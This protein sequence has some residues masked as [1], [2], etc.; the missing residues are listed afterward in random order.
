MEPVAG[1][2]VLMPRWISHC[3]FAFSI[4]MSSQSAAFCRDNQ[5]D[6]AGVTE[7]ISLTKARFESVKGG[8]TL[9]EV[10]A[11]LGSRVQIN[12]K[13]APFGFAAPEVIVV[14][15]EGTRRWV[16]VIFVPDKNGALRVLDTN[17]L[18]GTYKAYQGLR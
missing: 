16:G 15:R 17:Q 3:T 10:K 5:D 6:N 2:E 4:I 1:K 7:D 8:M 14:W 18:G 9:L 13:P 12:P 11:I